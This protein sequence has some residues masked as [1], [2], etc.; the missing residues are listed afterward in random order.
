[1]QMPDPENEGSRSCRSHYPKM[2]KIDYKPHISWMCL[3]KMVNNRSSTTD[4]IC[5]TCAMLHTDHDVY[6]LDLNLPS[7]YVVENLF[8]TYPTKETSSR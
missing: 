3:S 4:L 1:M 7:P 8:S 5:P 2:K 6:H